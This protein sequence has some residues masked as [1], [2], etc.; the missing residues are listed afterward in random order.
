MQDVCFI[1]AAALDLL[2][3]RVFHRISFRVSLQSQNLCEVIDRLGAASAKAQSLPAIIT[4]S[5]KLAYT[6]QRIYIFI[7]HDSDR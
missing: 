6:D 5:S 2:K 4:T 1:Y 3:L 7:Q